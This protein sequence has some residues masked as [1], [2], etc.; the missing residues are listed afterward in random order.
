MF[1]W[2]GT[3]FTQRLAT[4]QQLLTLQVKAK[5]KNKVVPVLN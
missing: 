5:G 3:A 2:K 4:T 1:L